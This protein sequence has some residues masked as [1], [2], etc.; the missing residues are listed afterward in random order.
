MGEEDT[1]KRLL[2]DENAFLRR[3]LEELQAVVENYDWHEKDLKRLKDAVKPIHGNVWDIQAAI[4]DVNE[5]EA[6]TKLLQP[7]GRQISNSYCVKQLVE[8]RDRYKA[9]VATALLDEVLSKLAPSAG[10]PL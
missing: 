7:G 2:L 5:L 6:I 1:A 9:M 8:D 4:N 3:K 10:G